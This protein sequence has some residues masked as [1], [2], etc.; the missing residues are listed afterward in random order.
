VAISVVGLAAVSDAQSPW[1][2]AGTEP[3]AAD[4]RCGAR[5]G[6]A[7]PT[8]TEA[9]AW[10]DAAVSAWAGHEMVRC[11]EEGATDRVVRRCD[12]VNDC[13]DAGSCSI[14]ATGVATCSSD[15][16]GCGGLVDQVQSG[17]F[18]D[19]RVSPTD[20]MGLPTCTGVPTMT[21]AGSNPARQVP[22][23]GASCPGV[24]AADAE[25]CPADENA[26]CTFRPACSADVTSDCNAALPMGSPIELMVGSSLQSGWMVPYGAPS[27]E[28]Y[29]HAMCVTYAEIA[30]TE[31]RCKL[32]AQLTRVCRGTVGWLNLRGCMAF[33]A[34]Q[35]RDDSD[36][37]GLHTGRGCR[38]S[39]R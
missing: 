27:I 7:C 17:T 10:G 6:L 23:P 25:A 34:A 35:P 30:D 33:V 2:A 21:L 13:A 39:L 15:E 20:G 4:Y 29:S 8:D 14:D 1:C 3:P 32:P 24:L 16:M 18:F 5:V 9:E 26:A 28:D 38:G 19:P 22:I 12:G 31:V 11:T 37:R 36:E